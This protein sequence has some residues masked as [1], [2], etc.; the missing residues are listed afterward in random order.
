[1]SCQNRLSQWETEVS[2]AFA[3]LSQPQI[4]GLVA[5]R[6]RASRCQDQLGLLKS[7]LCS[8]SCCAK[9]NKRCFSAYASGIW[10]ASR[11]VGKSGVTWRCP[12][13]L[14]P[15]WHGCYACGKAKSVNYHW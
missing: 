11:R 6:A 8:P 13:V 1:M 3:H 7:V 5:V 14:L 12:R 10:M 2:T 15:C 9:E 4:G